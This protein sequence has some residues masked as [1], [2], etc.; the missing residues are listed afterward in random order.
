MRLFKNYLQ[1][2]SVDLSYNNVEEEQGLLYCQNFKNMLALTITG[3]PFALRGPS[4]YH[5][6]EQTLSLQL[7]AVVINR[8][9]FTGESS[10]RV[11]YPKQVTFLSREVQK[12]LKPE[13]PLTHLM[14][15]FDAELNKG[16]ALPISEMEN[17]EFEDKANDFFITEKPH[18]A[19]ASKQTKEQQE[20]AH[21]QEKI[22]K[23]IK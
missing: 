12:T 21:R 6:L 14:L 7:S 23:E 18:L 20:E 8:S 10:Q 16:V 1:A 19:H 3:N 2:L 9:E 11:P 17:R 13:L 15:I 22:E 5:T 4:E